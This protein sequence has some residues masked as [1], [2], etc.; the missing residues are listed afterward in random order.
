MDNIPVDIKALGRLTSARTFEPKVDRE[1]GLVKTEKDTGR[2]QFAGQLVAFAEGG[3]MILPITV[4]AET[5]PKIAPGQDVIVT[6]LIAI[7]WATSEGSVRIAYRAASI[8]PA[9]SPA[10]AKVA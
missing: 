6:G 8:Q 7:P 4:A 1:T 10:P 2:T 3:A 5:A 9:S